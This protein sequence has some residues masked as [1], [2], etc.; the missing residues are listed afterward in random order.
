MRLPTVIIVNYHQNLML[1]CNRSY[2]LFEI[3]FE[4]Q[5]NLISCSLVQL[6]LDRGIFIFY[7]PRYTIYNI[8][9]FDMDDFPKGRLCGIQSIYY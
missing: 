1:Y 4:D 7:I 2:F 9:K 3:L 6:N 5:R 8:K